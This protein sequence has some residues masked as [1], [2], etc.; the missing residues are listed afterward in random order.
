MGTLLVLPMQCVVLCMYMTAQTALSH[1]FTYLYPPYLYI[2]ILIY[3][4]SLSLPPSFFHLVIFLLIYAFLPLNSLYPFL[5]FL[6]L[7][8]LAVFFCFLM[9]IVSI[10]EVPYVLGFNY[11]WWQFIPSLHH[12]VWE[13]VLLNIFLPF[14]L[15]DLQFMS[16]RSSLCPC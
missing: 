6:L 4:S 5:P 8:H 10:L 15:L 2:H 1:T 16:S 11:F 3:G 14:S 12:S 9:F 13:A 7:L